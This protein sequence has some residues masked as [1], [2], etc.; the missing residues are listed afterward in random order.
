MF[1]TK[2]SAKRRLQWTTVGYMTGFWCVVAVLQALYKCVNYNPVTKEMLLVAPKDYSIPVFILI[3]LIGPLIAGVIAA[4]FIV[5]YL[6]ER[7]KNQSYLTFIGVL[8]LVFFAFVL[9]L[10]TMV[11]W[12]FYTN[13][14]LLG[15][16]ASFGFFIKHFLVDPY[17]LRNI[18]SW[19]LIGFVT[20][21]MLQISDKYGPGILNKFILGK[22]FHPKEEERIFLFIDLNDSTSIAEKLGNIPF[23]KLLNSYFA[24]MTD[25]I[26]ECH[27]EIY[28][29]VG[30]EIVVTWKKEAGITNARCIR[31]F[32]EIERAI[33][34][35][36]SFYQ[37][38]FGLTPKFKAGLHLGKVIVGEIGIIKK[39]ISYI[40]DVLNTTSRIQHACKTLEQKIIISDPL[41]KEL[42]RQQNKYHFTDL[43]EALLRGKDLPI[44]LWGVN[45]SIQSRG[46]AHVSHN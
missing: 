23:F 25:S 38:E 31:C 45:D 17:A 6:K 32:F 22:Y 44:R 16:G 14:Q 13:E 10:N 12:M 2:F 21:T 8:G 27:G 11:S 41:F 1:K 24:D 7:L 46:T 20:V 42:S 26:L 39:D 29:Y 15:S 43:G 40:G 5:F 37:S 4:P 34:Q 18:L 35:R 9:L 36:E 3:N 19:M 30:D 33:A 28:Q